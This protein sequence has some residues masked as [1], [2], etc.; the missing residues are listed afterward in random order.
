MNHLRLPLI[1]SNRVIQSYRRLLLT[2]M[3]RLHMRS[4]KG[5]GRKPIISNPVLG[6]QLQACLLANPTIHRFII[7]GQ[8]T[9]PAL[10]KRLSLIFLLEVLSQRSPITI[11]NPLLKTFCFFG[12]IWGA[13]YCLASPKYNKKTNNFQNQLPLLVLTSLQWDDK[14]NVGFKNIIDE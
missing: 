12:G 7:P 2:C 5:K 8:L 6:A 4:P 13:H 1:E 11:V 3:L 9:S 14:L 10:P